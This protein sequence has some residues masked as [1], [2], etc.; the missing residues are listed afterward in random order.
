MVLKLSDQTPIAQGG[1][2]LIFIHPENNDWLIKVWHERFHE[3]QQKRTPFWIRVIRLKRY[4]SLLNELTEYLGVRE[5][6]HPKL[7]YIQQLVGLTD[8]D[9]G[10]GMVVKAIKQDNGKLA[11]TL[12][13]LVERQVFHEQHHQALEVF[14]EWMS[15]THIIVRDFSL[16]NL[17][18][19]ECNQRFV[20]IDGIGSKIGFSLRSL[21][22][23]Y[24]QKANHN[25]IVK[26]RTRL[27]KALG[28]R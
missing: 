23:R 22:R 26:F 3:K 21:S 4:W 2:R 1:E 20:L 7:E 18:W 6:P 9:L 24:N 10:F 13:D 28:N 5:D 27:A 8:T 19:D 17:I 25:R 11:P 16:N 15:N 14:F 12:K